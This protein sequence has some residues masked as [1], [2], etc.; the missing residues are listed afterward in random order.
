MKGMGLLLA[1]SLLVI[2]KQRE[3]AVRKEHEEKTAASDGS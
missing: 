3:D 2:A 1:A